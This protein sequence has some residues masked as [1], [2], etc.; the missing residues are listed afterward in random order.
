METEYLSPSNSTQKVTN[1]SVPYIDDLYKMNIALNQY[2]K[3]VLGNINWN[4][5]MKCFIKAAPT[6]HN[7]NIICI[8]IINLYN[9]MS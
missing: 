7:T 2:K 6:T 5:P 1:V 3:I 9:T 8:N 4:G